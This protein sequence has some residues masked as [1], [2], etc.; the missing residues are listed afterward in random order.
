ME[1]FLYKFVFCLFF[2]GASVYAYCEKWNQACYYLLMALVIF[3]ICPKQSA[4]T[5]NHFKDCT[6][7][8][9][10]EE[11]SEGDEK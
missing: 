2:A 5:Q 1:R 10:F 11:K 6:V 9:P 3:H 4:I 7:F 8:L